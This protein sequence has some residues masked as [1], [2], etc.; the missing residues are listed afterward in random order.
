VVAAAITAAR[1]AEPLTAEEEAATTAV[2]EAV[3]V[4]TAAVVVIAKINQ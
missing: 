3:A 1:V 2:V 4:H